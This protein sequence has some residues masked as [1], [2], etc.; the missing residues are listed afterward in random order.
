M[1]LDIGERE[2]ERKKPRTNTG[3]RTRI[4]MASG[5]P[6]LA[7]AAALLLMLCVTGVQQLAGQPPEVSV[8]LK[9]DGAT[10]EQQELF[11]LGWMLRGL[12]KCFEDPTR[13]CLEIAIEECG[14]KL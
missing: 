2:T 14:I 8:L 1:L 6:A 4:R 7:A 12:P 3:R 11:A 9:L 5:K 13:K 10:T